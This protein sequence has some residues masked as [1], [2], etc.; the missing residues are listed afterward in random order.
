MGWWAATHNAL[1]VLAIRLIVLI[2]LVF[3]SLLVISSHFKRFYLFIFRERKICAKNILIGCLLHAPNW[4]PGL[5]P[6]HVPWL[7]IKLVTLWFAGRHSIHWATPARAFF[8][9]LEFT[10]FRKILGT[11]NWPKIEFA[12]HYQEIKAKYD[13]VH[14]LQLVCPLD[15]LTKN[16][17]FKLWHEVQQF[18]VTWQGGG[19]GDPGGT[20]GRDQ[21]LFKM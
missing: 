8:T 12:E 18:F 10:F 6:R 2:L 4:A 14:K 13:L 17:K 21:N 7:G 5:Q 15:G 1:I 16:H 19:L 20:D 9:F 3:K 11:S